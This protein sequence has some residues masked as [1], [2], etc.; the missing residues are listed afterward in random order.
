[1]SASIMAAFNSHL[2]TLATEESIPVAWEN[3]SFS[4]PAGPYLRAF[5][6][7]ALTVGAALGAEA[8]NKHRGIFQVDCICPG[9]NGW[10]PCLVI[11]EQVRVQFKRG[12]RLMDGNLI[13]ESVSF[14]PGMMD[15]TRYK[16]P[17]SISY[18][19][20]LANT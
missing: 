13:V 3:V 2:N 15:G 7:P 17:V 16:I 12:T 20:F 19:A 14:G 5:L 4:P 9:G 8:S 6:L 10:G 18:W 11:A 1:M